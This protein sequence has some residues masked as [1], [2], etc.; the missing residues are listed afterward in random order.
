MTGTSRVTL[1]RSGAALLAL[2]L[3]AAGVV[4]GYL[5]SRST[6]R[7]SQPPPVKSGTQASGT[8]PAAAP[9]GPLPD[10][11]V[12]LTKDAV[13]RAG[14]VVE[15][16]GTGGES[17]G[18]RIPGVVEPNA[19]KQVIVTPLVSGRITRVLAELGEPVKRGQAL[20]QIFSPE[21][22]EAHTRFISARAQLEAHERELR[23][24]EKLVEIGAASRQEL[25]RIHAEH[26]ARSADV[27]S[28]RSRLEL[29]GVPRSAIDGMSPGKPVDA[30]TTVPAP[31]AGVV[32]ERAANVGLNVDPATKLFTVVDL[33]TVWVVADVYERDFSHIRVGSPVT[34][35]T[36]AYP[37]LALEGRIS[38]VDPQV[39]PETRTAKAR[40]EVRNPRSGLRLGMLAEV[41]VRTSS[42]SAVPS[43]PRTAVQNVGDRQVVYLGHPQQ[44]GKF[45]EREVRLG[46]A[47]GNQVPVLAGVKP[48]DI[49]VTE[50]S[51]YV[52]AE[53]ERLG[54][55]P[56]TESAAASPAPVPA[57]G[58]PRITVS[59]QGFQPAQVT[60]QAGIPARITF[61]RT[62][63]ATCATEVAVPSLKIKRALPL[64]QAVTLEFTPRKTGDVEFVCGMGMLRGTIVVQ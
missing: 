57:A 19:Y 58:E 17:G 8:S 62:S 32:T 10:V 29:L 5:L 16:V 12:T 45:I 50:G 63:D 46:D 41:L 56:P 33:S 49:I 52:R 35:T 44:P 55:R 30:I 25:E 59:D 11:T 48:G 9:G 39:S 23:R 26:T 40:I 36:A 14:I 4:A 38:Y 24:T 2:L 54:L 64:N 43:I 31:I 34:I 18:L 51:F 3:M 28:A 47:A 27:H 1:R 15:T 53:R 22:A 6:D 37:A 21:L 7:P 61:V 42:V 13:E 20:A 60:V